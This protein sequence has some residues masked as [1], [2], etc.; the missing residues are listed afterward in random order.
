MRGIV[1]EHE[2]A[3]AHRIRLE[4]FIAQRF[5]RLLA[6]DEAA[7]IVRHFGIEE[8]RGEWIFQCDLD[9]GIV[10]GFNGHIR[11]FPGVG[12]AIGIGRLFQR[13]DH[14]FRSQFV[15]RHVP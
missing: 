10:D 15:G 7:S 8:H 14:I 1:R 6:D 3:G 2:R 4:H 13:I 9:S 11:I 12:R 5:H